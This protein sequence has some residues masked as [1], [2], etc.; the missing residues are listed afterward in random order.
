M[1]IEEFQKSNKNSIYIAIVNS[2]DTKVHCLKDSNIEGKSLRIEV[3]SNEDK[4]KKY[5]LYFPEEGEILY[6]VLDEIICIVGKNISEKT[7]DKF[8]DIVKKKDKKVNILTP[9]MDK[10]SIV[11]YGIQQKKF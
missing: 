2:I 1:T 10:N 6:I 8:K 5:K 3:D 4:E 9:Q 11:D 7:L